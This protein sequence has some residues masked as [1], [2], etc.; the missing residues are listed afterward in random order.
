MTILKTWKAPKRMYKGFILQF[1]DGSLFEDGAWVVRIPGV[2][3]DFAGGFNS[4]E[5]AK[6]FVDN[7]LK[8]HNF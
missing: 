8:C 1:V 6:R 2:V 7:Y 5:K 4:F 3:G